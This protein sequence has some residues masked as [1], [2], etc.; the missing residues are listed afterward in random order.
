MSER[1]ILASKKILVSGGTGF[2]GAAAVP[3]L[4]D[5]HPGSA[6]TIIDRSPPRPQHALLQKA[7]FV[8][9]T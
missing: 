3:S 1:H 7:E 4:A 5:K 8:Q 9:E 6:I 2:V